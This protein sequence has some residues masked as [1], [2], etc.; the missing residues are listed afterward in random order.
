MVARQF[1][2]IPRLR[3]EGLLAAF[4]KLLGS[5]DKHHTYL[6]TDSVRYLYQP[7]DQYYVVLV[8]NKSSNILED[9]ETLQLI[10]RVTTDIC[11]GFDEEDVI[12]KALDLT[13]AF[14]EVITGGYREK[15]TLPQIHQYL[16]MDSQDE[17]LYEMIEKSKRREAM[18]EAKRRQ[19]QIEQDR[20]DS[21]QVQNDGVYGGNSSYTPQVITPYQPTSSTTMAS[22]SS[23]KAQPKR[24]RKGMS[25]GPVSKKNEFLD[26]LNIEIE[27]SH[28]EPELPPPQQQPQQQQQQQQQQ[29]EQ[30]NVHVLQ[31]EKISVVIQHDGDVSMEV[32][33]DLSVLINDPNCAKVFTVVQKPVTSVQYK[34]HPNIDKAR[35]SRESVLILKNPSQPYPTGNPLG[36]L[37]YR[38]VSSREEE[39]PLSVT[40]WPTQNGDGTTSCALECELQQQHMSLNFIEI[41]IPTRSFVPSVENVDGQ[42]HFDESAG[43]L[44]WQ[45]QS[46]DENVTSASLNFKV[47]VEGDSSIFFPIHVGFLSS[48]SVPNFQIEKVCLVENERAVP[49]SLESRLEVENY[50]IVHQG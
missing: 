34:T 49:F 18:E 37:K 9:L 22:I 43:V 28:Q 45:I 19:H 14:D 30:K 17:R 1:Q 10:V 41:H 12:H 16:E 27:S 21:R 7:L 13:F 50:E 26:K 24:E 29:V 4:P 44:V 36:V 20:R 6:E 15:V 11:R 2:N 48:S 33:G 40:C 25:L 8:T 32:K 23:P 39:L 31:D 5:A 42:Y 3:I 38:C 47:Q 35:F 46:L